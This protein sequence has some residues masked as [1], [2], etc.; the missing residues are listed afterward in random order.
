[1]KIGRKELT[2][3]GREIPIVGVDRNYGGH[4]FELFP[5]F[6][7]TGTGNDN[8]SFEQYFANLFLCI[9][10]KEIRQQCTD[11]RIQYYAPFGNPRMKQYH[12]G[13]E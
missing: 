6:A 7:T 4:C 1:M 5:S 12:T 9:R 3:R 2:L 10:I 13:E 8:I 11:D